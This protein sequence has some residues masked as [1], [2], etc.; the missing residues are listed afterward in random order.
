MRT[1][2]L[3]TA[4]LAVAAATAC[5]QGEHNGDV[6]IPPALADR[7]RVPAEQARTAA[8]AKVPGGEVRSG[9]LEEEGGA[10][11]YSFDIAAPGQSG[12]QEVQVD[13]VSGQVLTEEHET[14][15]EE[16]DEA[17]AED[18]EGDADAAT[19]P[20]P[21]ALVEESPGLLE[22]ATVVDEDARA[23]AQ[24]KVPGGAIVKAELEEENG[25]LIYSYDFRVEGQPGVQEVHVDANTGEVV[26]VEHEQG[27]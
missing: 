5:G 1:R 21:G 4:F 15:K 24:A 17:R 20:T 3:L 25:K 8:L 18:Q 27:G 2:T 19:E 11:I 9:E 23:T 16:A 6:D 13:A 12:V 7:A 22:R 10:L 14:P 26:S